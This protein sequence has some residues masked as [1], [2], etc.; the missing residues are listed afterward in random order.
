MIEYYENLTTKEM[1]E[2]DKEKTMVMIPLGATEQHGPQA[3]LGTDKMIADAMPQ[4]LR[5]K[6]EADEVDIDLLIF[7]TIPIGLS[8]EHMPFSGTV[9]FRPETYYQMLKDIVLSIA[10][11]GFRKIIFLICHGGNRPVVDLLSRQL[12]YEK[13]IYIF[14]LGSGAFLDPEVQA[15]ISPDNTWDFHGGEMETSMVLA[16]HPETVK[17]AYSETGYKS[18]GFEN[19]Q[20]LNFSGSCALNWMGTDLRTKEGKP[21]GIG[22]NPKGAT[23]EK[24]SIIFKRSIE[25]IIPGILEIRDFKI[26]SH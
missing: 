6:L 18:G 24:G 3:P 10:E 21:I 16:I 5:D 23:A 17:L 11:H 9:S 25:A 8:V 13:G 2:V 7:P 19:K 4:F 14:A 12:R 20:H 1:A 26:Q 15:T 22:G